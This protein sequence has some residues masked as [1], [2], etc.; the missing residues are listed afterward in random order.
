MAD[1]INTLQSILKG[2]FFHPQWHTDRLHVRSRRKLMLIQESLVVDIGSGNSANE[3]LLGNN[4]QLLRL[5]YPDTNKRYTSLPDIFA[6]ACRLP[7]A[8]QS[9]D[10]ILLLEVL[11][12]IPDHAQALAEAFRALKP[13]GKL[14]LSVPFLYPLHDTPFD[15]FRFTPYGLKHILSN[16]GF[17]VVEEIRH[18]NSFSTAFQLL[19]LAIMELVQKI[20]THSRILGITGAVIAY[21]LCLFNN[22]TGY[23]LS[24]LPGSSLA[25]GYFIIAQ[26][27]EV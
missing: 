22:F 9:V 24:F 7:L 17:Q 14:Y 5:D 27:K 2:S 6:D 20:H 8:D 13:G 1:L 26:R 18:G 3:T 4:N 10:V 21:P 12:H 23:A 19:N 25:F 15:F 11:E 16:Q